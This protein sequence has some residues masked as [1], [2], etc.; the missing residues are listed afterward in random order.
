MF[1]GWNGSSS[2]LSWHRLCWLW[3]WRERAFLWTTKTVSTPLFCTVHSRKRCKVMGLCGKD[4]WDLRALRSSKPP[5]SFGHSKRSMVRALPPSSLLLSG[6]PCT[7]KANVVC[8]SIWEIK[9][10]F[11]EGSKHNKWRWDK[12]C[13]QKDPRTPCYQLQIT[14][15]ALQWLVCSYSE[16][17][18]CTWQCQS[19]EAIRWQPVF[20]K[21]FLIEGCK[22]LS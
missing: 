20:P 17:V 16:K 13:C 18:V 19:L 9:H 6:Q 5:G 3:R 22:P 15:K 4:I 2:T 10:L 1:G 14:T 12:K 11:D 8:K 21:A 7:Y